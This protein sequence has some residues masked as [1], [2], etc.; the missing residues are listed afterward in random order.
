M[1]TVPK[2]F[3]G[4]VAFAI[5]A[6]ISYLT[7]RALGPR[8][9]V[10]SNGYVY[11][12]AEKNSLFSYAP[13][14]DHSARVGD[15]FINGFPTYEEAQELIKYLQSGDKGK[16]W[17]SV[18]GPVKRNEKS[19]LN[20]IRVEDSYS[21]PPAPA[22]KYVAASTEGFVVGKTSYRDIRGDIWVYTGTNPDEVNDYRNWKRAESE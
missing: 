2:I 20:V 21:L 4:V 5:L 19:T 10:E 6:V 16:T 3:V 18:S 8:Y 1:K 11:R 9:R 14:P 17:R 13:V 15:R 7:M 22:S 12:V